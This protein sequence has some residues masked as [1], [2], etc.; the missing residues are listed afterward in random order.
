[1]A[2]L[3]SRRQRKKPTKPMTVTNNEIKN[4]VSITFRYQH[5]TGTRRK[6]GS[7]PGRTGTFRQFEMYP[8]E[9]QIPSCSGHYPWSLQ[10]RTGLLGTRL[11]NPPGAKLRILLHQATKALDARFKTMRTFW[12]DERG[13]D[14]I[15]Y[16]LLMAFVALASSALFFSAGSSVQAIWN[17]ANGQLTAANSNAS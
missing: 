2:N 9:R 6:A 10:N 5:R 4:T 13:Q 1:L 14:L 7:Y 17:T 12:R 16:T 11:R 3:A 8:L 15:E